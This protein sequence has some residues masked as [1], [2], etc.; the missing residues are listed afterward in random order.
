MSVTIPLTPAG[1]EK[2]KEELERLKREGRP[3]ISQA[4]ADARAHGDLKENAEYHA[5]KEQQ[6]VM[7]KRIRHLESQVAQAQVIDISSL[8]D[9]DKIVFGV[10]VEVM[11]CDSEKTLAFQIVGDYE[12]DL[13]Q[14]LLS[15]SSPIARAL[16]GK[17]QGDIVEVEAP[18]GT[19]CYEVMQITYPT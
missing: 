10:H 4:I 17:C 18:S 3:R 2:L 11:D 12:A 15:V 19:I 7:E 1:F 16:I 9:Q 14:G 5:A 13:K 8:K 6:R